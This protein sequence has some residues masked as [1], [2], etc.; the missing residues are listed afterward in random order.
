MLNKNEKGKILPFI[1]KYKYIIATLIFLVWIVFLDDN[2]II[3]RYREYKKYKELKQSERYY[4]EKNKKD[5]KELEDLKKNE[6]LEKIAREKYF[7][8]KKD[9]DIFVIIRK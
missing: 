3:E 4:I 8:K 7:M 2:N 6:E 5:H 1:Q 9:E